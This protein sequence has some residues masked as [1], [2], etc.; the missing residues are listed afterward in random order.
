MV[1]GCLARGE[2]YFLPLLQWETGSSK[3]RTTQRGRS[4]RFL[5]AV[6]H[7][8]MGQAQLSGHELVGGVGHCLLVCGG[9]SHP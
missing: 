4:L 7:T 5:R 6:A 3:G 9:L 8:R 1:P 2:L